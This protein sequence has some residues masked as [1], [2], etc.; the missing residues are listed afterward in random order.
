MDI[1]SGKPYPS[2]ALSNFAPRPFVFRGV[3]CASMEGLL[4][5]LK[6]ENP[7]MQRHVCT[8]VGIAAKRKGKP[9]KWQKTQTLWWQGEPIKRDSEE[10]QVLLDE[11]YEALFKNEKAKAALLATGNAKLTHSIG[12]HKEN[13]TVLTRNEFCRRLMH[14]RAVL[15]AQKAGVEF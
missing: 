3:E 15:Q 4:Q 7:E 8:L 11:A 14:I 6:F 12:W 1:K 2:G 9:K 5:A 13:E 10:Y